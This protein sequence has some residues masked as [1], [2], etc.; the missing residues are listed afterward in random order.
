MCV[1]VRLL[2]ELVGE[3]GSW[4]LGEPGGRDKGY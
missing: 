2:V 3:G 4:S 1:K